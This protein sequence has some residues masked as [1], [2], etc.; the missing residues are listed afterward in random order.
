MDLEQVLNMGVAAV[1]VREELAEFA[2][3][4]GHSA[5]N[6]DQ[7]RLANAESHQGKPPGG[8]FC[9]YGTKAIRVAHASL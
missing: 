2:G 8:F 3:V 9:S 1:I 5:Q 4:G 6:L 7:P